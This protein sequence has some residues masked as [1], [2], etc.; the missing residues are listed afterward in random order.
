MW[1]HHQRLINCC[2]FLVTDSRQQILPQL[3]ELYL[4][5]VLWCRWCLIIS[6]VQYCL[7]LNSTNVCWNIEF[8]VISHLTFQFNTLYGYLHLEWYLSHSNILFWMFCILKFRSFKYVCYRILWIQMTESQ[9]TAHVSQLNAIIED[10]QQKLL[11]RD[12]DLQS[13]A[14]AARHDIVHST[15]QSAYHTPVCILLLLH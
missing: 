7:A 10:L 2:N 3:R 4:R 13:C 9:Y 6:P 12:F 15:P 11:D 14:D 5:V 8:F 1:L